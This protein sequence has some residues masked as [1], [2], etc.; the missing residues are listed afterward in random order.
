MGHIGTLGFFAFISAAADF[1]KRITALFAELFLT[2]YP[3]VYF[4]AVDMFHMFLS[5]IDGTLLRIFL[6]C[7]GVS[8]FPI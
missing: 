7:H 3:A 8:S 6:C 1:F 5:Q 2:V 4:S